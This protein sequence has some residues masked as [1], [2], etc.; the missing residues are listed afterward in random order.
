MNFENF[1]R[2]QHSL[3]TINAIHEEE[4]T[5]PNGAQ[6]NVLDDNKNVIG[7]IRRFY[8]GL[9]GYW[10]G[11]IYLKDT[12]WENEPDLNPNDLDFEDE[13]PEN[14]IQELTFQSDDVVGWDH[15]HWWDIKSKLN[16]TTNEI[17]INEVHF[18]HYLAQNYGVKK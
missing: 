6:I 3:E 1:K 15:N 13:F 7:Y 12:K 4:N 8:M 14:M 2:P 10:C 18:M 5:I 16:Y 17:V 9:T 11:Y